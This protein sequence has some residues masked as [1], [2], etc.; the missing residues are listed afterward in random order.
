MPLCCTGC[1][2]VSAQRRRP[3]KL[4]PLKVSQSATM[5]G[6][7]VVQWD[8]Y[9]GEIE[10]KCRQQ[11]TTTWMDVD[12]LSSQLV[13]V[14]TGQS[15][16][17]AS[18]R[19][20]VGGLEYGK[21]YQFTW[22]GKNKTGRG[23]LSNPVT[24]ATQAQDDKQSPKVLILNTDTDSATFSW[25]PTSVD[26]SVHSVVIKIRKLLP[27]VSCNPWKYLDSKSDELV[28]SGKKCSAFSVDTST[29]LCTGLDPGVEYEVVAQSGNNSGY[30]KLSDPISFHT[31]D[32]DNDQ[33]VLSCSYVSR[34]T[35]TLQWTIPDN[36]DGYFISIRARKKYISEEWMM[37]DYFSTSIKSYK[38]S[39]SPPASQ[40]PFIIRK[41][42][43]CSTYEFSA[44]LLTSNG[45]TAW[46]DTI[47]V[48]TQAGMLPIS[49]GKVTSC[50]AHLE[51]KAPDQAINVALRC[52]R[53]DPSEPQEWQH[54]D[55]RS[56][57]L[58][59]LGKGIAARACEGAL[60][61]R[62]LKEKTKYECSI[63]AKTVSGWGPYSQTRV[64]E[65]LSASKCVM[66]CMKATTSSLTL[67]LNLPSSQ[68]KAEEVTVLCRKGGE[69]KWDEIDAE[70]G[71]IVATGKGSTL[72]EG[73]IC[74]SGLDEGAQYE[75]DISKNR[76]TQQSPPLVVNLGTQIS[77]KEPAASGCA[78]F[79]R[80]KVAL[81]AK[82][83]E[84]PTLLNHLV[85]E[86]D[87]CFCR[88]CHTDSAVYE[89]GGSDYILPLGWCRI[90][91]KTCKSAALEQ[92]AF[93][94]WHTCYHGTSPDHL[95]D[96]LCCGQ[97]LK[98]G[99]TTPRGGKIPVR[100]G[101]IQRGFKR[102]NSH[103]GKSEF[104]DPPSLIFFS[105]SIRYCDYGRA[106][107]TEHS[108]NG[109]RYRFALQVCD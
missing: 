74:I 50:A 26:D 48:T 13:P 7:V 85:D 18:G 73:T 71:K 47:T 38:E 46:S 22:C 66:K 55:S 51:W 103:S 11:G 79:R 101:H 63:C 61:L 69:K 68:G 54:V 32:L 24:I 25:E 81:L 41:L 77:Y 102:T 1:F 4:G 97:L 100:D 21:V 108:F 20:V 70:V 31:H 5:P 59:P 8:H 89:R 84:R 88:G 9:Q 92:I 29:A 39:W 17:T 23:P 10:I 82:L 91:V 90:G 42:D 28:A 15:I 96:I 72:T 99:S 65:T 27:D 86:V 62:G 109:Y 57:V 78:M 94:N 93:K 67:R 83:N 6:A 104:F 49:I 80:C 2:S 56:N 105:P 95:Y 33:L 64:F 87:R 35:A 36:E 40:N 60:L 76:G 19:L 37:I 107:M 53:L 14:G 106:Y 52:R 16:D 3:Q 44:R 12:A 58:V 45:P 75:F 34:S 98:P 30:G 43:E